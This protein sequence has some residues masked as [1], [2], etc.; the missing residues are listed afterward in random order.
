[1]FSKY[2]FVA[3]LTLSTLVAADCSSVTQ[4]GA[5]FTFDTAYTCGQFANGD[6]WVVGPVTITA[7]S[8]DWDGTHNGWMVDPTYSSAQ[9]FNGALASYSAAL[10]PA[11]P[12]TLSGVKSVV[13]AVGGTG[14]V[15]SVIKNAAVLT[16][17]TESPA[18][19]GAGYFRP[20]YSG[21]EKPLI[22]TSA[23]RTDLL[24]SYTPTASTPTLA[25]IVATYT[26]GLRLDYRS[27][28]ARTFRPYDV[29]MNYAPD[30]APEVNEAMLR[31]MLNDSIEDKLP[32]LIQF[33]QHALD[34]AYSIKQG[35][36][37]TGTGH[38]PN[39]RIFGA[40][41]AIM[42]GLEDIADYMKTAVG[43]HEDL[44]LYEGINGP[45]W[46]QADSTELQ[47][48]AYV[49][50]EAGS[51]SH[52][53]PYNFI[54]GGKAGTSYDLLTA[55]AQKGQALIYTLFPQLKTVVPAD[56]LSIL[57]RYGERWRNVGTWALPDPAA[58]YDGTPANYGVTYG[59][60]GS[61][62]YIAGSGRFPSA[63]GT[64]LDGGFNKSA[65]VE[66]MWA[67]HYNNPVAPSAASRRTVQGR[68]SISGNARMQ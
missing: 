24:P 59:P 32:A 22:A 8:P 23:L 35:Y 9:G 47:Y 43:F 16:I 62:G 7:M 38:N 19:G 12:L 57:V 13:K 48:W 29:M 37:A 51:R 3:L 17:L 53:D 63:H 6:W 18:G 25:S 50:N 4:Y 58:P 33:T 15:T 52:K 40:W 5:T 34:Q 67:A 66:A 11:L 56:K 44:Y 14:D 26:K 55:Q 2:I 28:D 21:T 1:M 68:V 49:Q 10:R 42:L 46:G 60:N 39:R 65:F 30:L 54:D 61:G 27:E 64:N 41:A 36:R 45:L 20:P 31:V